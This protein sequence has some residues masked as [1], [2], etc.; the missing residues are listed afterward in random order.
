MNNSLINVVQQGFRIAIGATA[1]CV[2]TLQDPQKRAETLS[3]LQTELSQ[4]TQQWSEK[5]EVTEQ[6]AK[7]FMENLMSQRGWSTNRASTSTS[8]ST[9]TPAN[10]NINSDIQELTEEI[11]ALKLELEKLRNQQDS[12]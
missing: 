8:N 12:E 9:S 4:K 11:I 2:E 1:D 10:S 6:Q 5:G 3:E 7:E